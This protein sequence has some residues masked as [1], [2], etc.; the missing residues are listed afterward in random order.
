MDFCIEDTRKKSVPKIKELIKDGVITLRAL[1]F[2]ALLLPQEGSA[3]TGGIQGTINSVAISAA[4]SNL[5]VATNSS[6][7][8]PTPQIR[9]AW[10]P[11][12]FWGVNVDM[13]LVTGSD[14]RELSEVWNVNTIRLNLRIREIQF[15]Q[16]DNDPY[17]LN[18][19]DLWE[20][21][22][23]IDLCER[24]GLRVILA[25]H[26]PLD[27]REWFMPGG[28]D[29]RI[30]SDF[31]YHDYLV[32]YWRTLAE[33]YANRGPVIAGYDIVNEPD[34]G[35]QVEGSPSDWNLL[36]G[37]ITTAI[38]QADR[39][40]TII[41][42]SI[43]LAKPIAFDLLEPT[44]DDNTVYD[45]HFYSPYAFVSQGGQDPDG[46][47]LPLNV[48]YPGN[49]GG[50]Y[51]DKNRMLQELELVIA[52]QE[53]Y[54]VPILCGEFGVGRLAPSASAV[55]YL[56]DL[57]SICDEYNWSSLYWCFREGEGNLSNLETEGGIDDYTVVGTN[58][59]RFQAIRPYFSR[60]N[61]WSGPMTG[62]PVYKPTIRFDEYHAELNTLSEQRAQ[63][64]NSSHPE[65]FL[66]GRFARRAEDCFDVVRSL[67]PLR[68]DTL[69]D[70]NILILAA[71]QNALT[72]E[73]VTDTVR[74]VSEGGGLLVLGD[75]SV[76]DRLNSLMVNFGMTYGQ[77]ILGSHTPLWDA[78]SFVVTNLNQ[79][80]F[81]T[82]GIHELHANWTGVLENLGDALVL[83]E[84]EADSWLDANMNGIQDP[85]EQNGPYA[86]ALAKQFGKGRV[87]AVADN[88]FFDAAIL[89]S[90]NRRFIRHAL[91]WLAQIANSFS[92]DP[93]S[94]TAPLTVQFT[95]ESVLGALPIE[96]WHWDFGD[97]GESDEPNPV[98]V[99]EEPG[100]YPVSL[101]VSTATGSDTWTRVHY[102]QVMVVMPV[103]GWTGLALV[104]ALLCLCAVQ[105]VRRRVK[106]VAQR[107]WGEER[108]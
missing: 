80:H 58:G 71:P 60:N 16:D 75:C 108:A 78:Q 11:D 25:N 2:F 35:D 54:Q 69:R 106:T 12:V 79:T 87:L 27:S 39:A 86:F 13:S 38:R 107:T 101:T 90:E 44:G 55:E 21:D 65:W 88:G 81:I 10:G 19:A 61:R 73:E 105:I 15:I 51:W 26:R 67:Q 45:F 18:E 62:R 5:P 50:E 63:E 6:P 57:L 82:K 37:K 46:S 68:Y 28:K 14:L 104:A 56:Q 34:P 41:V 47:T 49:I 84:T 52:F 43:W 30:W 77:G 99:Y 74:F 3:T 9:S 98:H 48:T 32:F 4:A 24:L 53:Q 92:G 40:H 96:T 31:L 83:A 89:L 100:E 103:L 72:A 1:V 42:E 91:A 23:Y 64:I 29:R 36:A 20:L 17:H 66:F 102:I 94:G 22:R 76:G 8:S 70:T 33:R 7:D 85:D 95:D 59:P 97:G 93:T